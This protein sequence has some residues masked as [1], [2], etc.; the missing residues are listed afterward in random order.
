MPEQIQGPHQRLTVGDVEGGS[1]QRVAQLL[2]LGG[3]H[4]GVD[5]ADADVGAVPRRHLGVH[6]VQGALVVGQPE[7]HAEHV[8]GVQRLYGYGF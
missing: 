6:P 2:V 5:V 8:G 1:L 7:R 4:N 3:R